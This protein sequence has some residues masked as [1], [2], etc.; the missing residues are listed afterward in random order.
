MTAKRSPKARNTG[1]MLPQ[2]PDSSFDV[3]SWEWN[4]QTDKI[5][6]SDD[7]L[8]TLG[9]RAEDAPTTFAQLTSLFHPDDLEDVWAVVNDALEGEASFHVDH[10]IIKTDGQ[11]LNVRVFGVVERDAEAKATRVIGLAQDVTA[12]LNT[13]A[14]LRFSEHRV[15]SILNTA[16][17]AI[18]TTDEHG[19]IESF[20][21]AAEGTFGYAEAEVIGKNVSVLMPSPYR[22][23]HDT[24]IR[25]Y[26]ETG[27]EKI[28]GIGR[29]VKGRRKDGSLFP[30]ELAV[31][32]VQV[33]GRR[34][35]TGIIKDVSDRRRL[36]QEILRISDQEQ[37]RIGQDLHDGLG[38]MLTG[39]GLLSQH[40]ARQLSEIDPDAAEQ[41]Q[42]ITSLIRE[43]DQQ[44]RALARGLVPVDIEAEGLT[45]ALKRLSKNAQTLFGIVCQVRIM[46]EPAAVDASV[47]T[48][49]FRIAQEAVS[50]AV[51]HGRA[52]EVSV[53]LAFSPDRIRI[54]IRDNGV[55]FP[56]ERSGESGMGVHIMHYRARIIGGTL[57]VRSIQDE[58][59]SVT[60]T[61]PLVVRNQRN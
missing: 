49:L 26:L 22:E 25:N 5:R 18:V 58:G 56:R 45:T 54:R 19:I 48:H 3:G 39:I 17:D 41:A 14:A 52:T 34:I 8:Q 42:E 30:L 40:L 35:F 43:A 51:K 53:A 29:E 6:L 4:I 27:E 21:R 60:C 13:Q 11:L 15:R 16:V 61:V 31:S 55:G 20:N 24:Y 23:E 10:R 57:E 46:G 36:E 33:E 12:A 1:G 2:E 50:N 59:T 44:A 7:L 37:R 38:Q 9:L 32:E 47:V 28:I